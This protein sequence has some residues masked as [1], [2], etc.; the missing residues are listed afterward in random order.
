MDWDLILFIMWYMLLSIILSIS[1]WTA[2]TIINIV[3][4]RCRVVPLGGPNGASPLLMSLAFGTPVGTVGGLTPG[5]SN[6]KLS[7]LVSLFSGVFTCCQRYIQLERK[8]PNRSATFLI[9]FFWVSFCQLFQVSFFIRVLKSAT[10]C[11]SLMGVKLQFKIIN[12]TF[13]FRNV[14]PFTFW[15]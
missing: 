11:K 9:F 12:P 7:P 13:Q 1:R 4:N 5:A 2:S 3:P 6:W 14:F 8:S 15:G 10:C